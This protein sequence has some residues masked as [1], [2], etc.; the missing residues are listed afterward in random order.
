MDC[1]KISSGFKGGAGEVR[2]GVTEVPA[3]AEK[4]ALGP[5]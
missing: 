2:P 5:N 1:S 4:I 3:R